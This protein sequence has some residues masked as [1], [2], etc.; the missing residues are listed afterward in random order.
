VPLGVFGL[1]LVP[2]QLLAIMGALAAYRLPRIFGFTRSMALL[3]ITPALALM[4]MGLTDRL[5]M[6]GGFAVSRLAFSLRMPLAID[7]INPRTD[8]E[9]RATVLSVQP[10]GR[11]LVLAVM[12]PLV[13][14]IAERSFT[15]TFAAIGALTLVTGGTAYLLWLHAGRTSEKLQAR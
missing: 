8:S 15:G 6:F 11:S 3:L 2:V 13:G 7:Y 5:A 10:L 12:A 4:L 14:L 9:I 1:F